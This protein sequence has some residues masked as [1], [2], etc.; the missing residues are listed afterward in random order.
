MNRFSQTFTAQPQHI[1]ELGH[2]M[3]AV[4]RMAMDLDEREKQ[5]EVDVPVRTVYNQWTQ[6]EDFPRFME[7]VRE[8]RQLDDAHLHW[9]ADRHGRTVE[10]DSEIVEQ[11]P[12]S[13]D[14]R[15][16]LYVEDNVSNVRLLERGQ[17]R[18]Q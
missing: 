5:I 2:L 10:W 17:E 9:R 15:M 11:V 1:D 13:S 8:V 3:Q 6:F 16:V 14:A 4:N 7:G 18:D 12:D